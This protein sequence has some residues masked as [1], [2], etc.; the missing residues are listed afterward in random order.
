[1]IRLKTLE[2]TYILI[3]PDYIIMAEPAGRDIT[4]ITVDIHKKDGGLTHI[5]VQISLDELNNVI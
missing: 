4:E 5:R 1:M 2:N 3:N